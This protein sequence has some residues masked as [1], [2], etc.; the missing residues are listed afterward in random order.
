M[1][2]GLR[3]AALTVH[4]VSSVGWMG[5]VG[6]FLALAVTGATG[7]DV[8]AVSASCM[9]M[10]PIIWAVIVPLAFAALITG[11][12]SALGSPWGLLRHYWVFFKLL[13]TAGATAALTLHTRI[14]DRL[15]ADAAHGPVPLYDGSAQAQ[16]VVVSAGALLVLT[17]VTVLSVYK[18]KGAIQYGPPLRRP[19]TRP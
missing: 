13:L 7:Q 6:A 3:K 4:V 15:A 11:V 18:P 16:L 14:V 10:R 9:A 8:P 19:A 12:V 5:A 17:V 1:P 2:P